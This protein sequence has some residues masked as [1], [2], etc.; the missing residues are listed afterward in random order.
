MRARYIKALKKGLLK[1]M[2]KMGISTLSSYQGAQI[3]E[4]VGIDQVVIDKY[5]TGTASRIRGVGLRE[6]AEE[7]LARH[8]RA[9][10]PHASTVRDVGGHH[11]WRT[12]GEA[13]LWNPETISRLQNAV[14]LEDAGSYREFAR[15]INEP[16]P[17]PAHAARP[18]GSVAGRSGR[19]ARQR[20]AGERNRQAVR[21]RAPCPSAAFPRKRT[22]TWPSP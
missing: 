19:A 10:G 6:I 5:F 12:T 17:P 9:F 18:L 13:H 7:A 22:R 4:A 14:R 2:S 16:R 15:I 21:H 1:I 3:F 11:H 20:R 8:A